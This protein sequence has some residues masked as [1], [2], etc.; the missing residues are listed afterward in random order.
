[1]EGKSMNNMELAVIL[2]K[3]SKVICENK[4]TDV[5]VNTVALT[6]KGLKVQGIRKML[7]GGEPCSDKVEADF[8]KQMREIDTHFKQESHNYIGTWVYRKVFKTL[9]LKYN[10]MNFFKYKDKNFF[11]RNKLLP[12]IPKMRV[13][14]TG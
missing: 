1:M 13:G 11:S 10:D 6:L 9:H 4:S 8:Q 2:G 12:P 5:V 7:D 3:V 14:T